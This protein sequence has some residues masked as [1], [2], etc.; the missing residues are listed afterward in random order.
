MLYI[1]RKEHFSSSHILRNLNIS[2]TENKD[3]FGKC[4]NFHGHNYYLEVT[5]KGTPDAKSGYVM[6]LKIMNRI[7]MEEVIDLV[8]HKFLNE[9]PM[10]KDI[11]PTT[12]NIAI[13]FWNI[14]KTK[15]KGD[16]YCLHSIKLFETEKNS[17]LYEGD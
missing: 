12:E 14:L 4:N 1:T 9:L 5:I 3:L 11:I 13:V 2:E 8:D 7:I 6:D 15:L 17:V 10:F 16:N